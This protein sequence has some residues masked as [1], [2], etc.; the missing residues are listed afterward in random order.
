[1]FA[2]LIAVQA[3]RAEGED[4]EEFE[5]F[6]ASGQVHERA[7]YLDGGLSEEGEANWLRCCTGWGDG[8]VGRLFG[9]F[10]GHAVAGGEGVEH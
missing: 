1:M 6:G 2:D 7:V 5:C 8:E 4:D 10:G 9:V 3:L